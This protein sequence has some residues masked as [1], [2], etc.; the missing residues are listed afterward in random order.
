MNP[1]PERRAQTGAVNEDVAGERRAP[2]I[3]QALSLQTRFSNY[4]ALG[5]IAIVGVAL[6]LWYYTHAVTPKGHPAVRHGM[7]KATSDD[8]PV[9]SLGPIRM[10]LL[11]TSVVDG[12]SRER[13][14]DSQDAVATAP[15]P[16]ASVLTPS[17]VI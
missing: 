4:L 6:L 10:P 17:A 7:P 8:V 3:A 5:L 11:A 9:P 15:A 1:N 14:A 2:V 16:D 13:N 12:P